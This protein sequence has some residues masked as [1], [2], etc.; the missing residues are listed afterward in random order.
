[1]TRKKRIRPSEKVGLKLAQAERKMLLDEIHLLPKE[2]EQAVRATPP[3]EPVMLALD[4]L[5]DLAGHVAAQANHAS[6]TKLQT[7]LDRI[8]KKIED[9]LDRYTD[10]P[11]PATGE[12]PTT[13]L[14]ETLI[15]MLLADGPTLL[16]VPAKPKK[17]EDQYPLKL[18]GKQREA[19]IH[20]T[21]LRRGLKAKL[22]Q[23]PE[24]AQTIGLTRT[25]LD[26]MAREVDTAVEYAPSPFKKPIQAVMS[27]LDDLLGELEE[28]EPVKRSGKGGK[29]GDQIYQLKITLKDIKPP[30]WRRLQVADCTLRDLHEVIQIAMGWTDSHLHQFIVRGDYY[31]P[32]APD[33]FGFGTDMDVE[34][35]DVALLSQILRSTKKFRYEYDFG[36]GW[37]HEML[38][39]KVVQREPKAQYPRCVDGKR[40]C[41]PED[42]GGPWGYAD[43]LAAISDPEHEDHEEL[44]EWVGGDFDPEEFSV[45]EVNEALRQF[46]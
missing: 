36:D 18:T 28:Q 25:E 6:D 12:G 17:D 4:D 15:D 23:V 31:G 42:C 45:V 9:L 8:Y 43:F 1:M 22:R 13:G 44:R 14:A 34:D 41:P 2:V 29:R 10:Q 27:K 7:S 38:L 33:D 11:E 37:Q 20:A 21:R 3:S 35:E 26:E 24:G 39:E 40:C 46:T 32:Q 19:L 16:P 5:D 30:I